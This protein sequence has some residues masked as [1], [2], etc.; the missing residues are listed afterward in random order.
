MRMKV[1]EVWMKLLAQLGLFRH[2]H[3]AI[4]AH[5]SFTNK[6]KKKNIPINRDAYH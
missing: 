1:G 5:I 4:E 6:H 3:Q 2:E